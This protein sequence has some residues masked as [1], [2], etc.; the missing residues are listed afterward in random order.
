[1]PLSLHDQAATG[2]TTT[3]RLDH[4]EITPPASTDGA[5]IPATVSRFSS[6]S[7]LIPDNGFYTLIKELQ[8]QEFK[9]RV[10]TQ[11]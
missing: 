2:T 11:E 4:I 5:S 8:Q 7:W 10:P 1:M 3:W 9:V 6:K